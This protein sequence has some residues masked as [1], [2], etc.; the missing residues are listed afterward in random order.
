MSC[1]ISQ[2]CTPFSSRPIAGCDS[3]VSN[4]AISDS[5][6]R[7]I[8]YPFEESIAARCKMLCS[9]LVWPYRRVYYENFTYHTLAG[10]VLYARGI[11]A[12][13]RLPDDLVWTCRF[14]T[15][16]RLCRT[17]SLSARDRNH[18]KRTHDRSVLGGAVRQR[19]CPASRP[20]SSTPTAR[21]TRSMRFPSGYRK[22]RF[23]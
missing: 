8:M 1:G 9:F 7:K 4:R 23:C 11:C 22:C 20:L 13:W 12:A 14:V 2:S 15:V 3:V 21:T 5:R 6:S 19:A 10:R 16:R 17:Q 18:L